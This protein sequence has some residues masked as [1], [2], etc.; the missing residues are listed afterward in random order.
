MIEFLLYVMLL[1]LG[2]L[3]LTTLYLSYTISKIKKELKRMKFA[4]DEDV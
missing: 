1:T 3:A 2:S 4:E